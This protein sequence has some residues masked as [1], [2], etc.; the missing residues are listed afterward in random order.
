MIFAP[1]SERLT[2]EVVLI[3]MQLITNDRD[4]IIQQIRDYFAGTDVRRVFLFGSLACNESFSASDVDLMME[5]DQPIGYLKIIGYKLA[6]EEFLHRKVDLLTPEGISPKI[7][8]YIQKDLT[9]IYD[10]AR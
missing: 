5:V 7:R 8:S 6:L 4:H 3:I 10:S 2:S 1:F 9:L